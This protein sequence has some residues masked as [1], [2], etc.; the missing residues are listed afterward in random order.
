MLS[1]EEKRQMIDLFARYVIAGNK[2]GIVN[3]LDKE[4][5]YEIHSFEFKIMV[6]KRAEYVSELLSRRLNYLRYNDVLK[7]EMIRQN[8]TDGGDWLLLMNDGLFPYIAYIEED[9]SAA[10]LAFEFND[11]HI[12]S[13]RFCYSYPGC[14]R[15]SFLERFD[16]D[17]NEK[18]TQLGYI[19]Y[20]LAVEAVFMRKYGDIPMPD[21]MNR[22][23]YIFWNHFINT[24][25]DFKDKV[26]RA[27]VNTA[28]IPLDDDEFFSE[29]NFGG[30]EW[31]E[32]DDEDDL[33]WSD[34]DPPF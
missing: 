14:L 1:P 4:G 12:T 3:L 22:I 31:D 9:D 17:V 6:C 28:G 34:E 25:F 8:A 27:H 20:G 24:S 21:F 33:W 29:E 13:I 32:E 16:R 26:D 15:Q 19:N 30:A 18:L 2:K 5:A 11:H 7:Y 10:A 23:E